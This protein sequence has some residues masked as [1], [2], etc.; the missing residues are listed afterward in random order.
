MTRSKTAYRQI[1]EEQLKTDILNLGQETLGLAWAF[2]IL[3]PTPSDTLPP[4]RQHLLT[5]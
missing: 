5:L 3:N 2:K 1:L 4:T